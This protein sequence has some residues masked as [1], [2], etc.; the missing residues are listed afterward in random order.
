MPWNNI[1][2]II[3]HITITTNLQMTSFSVQCPLHI[4]TIISTVT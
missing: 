1:I 4:V 3:F 2:K